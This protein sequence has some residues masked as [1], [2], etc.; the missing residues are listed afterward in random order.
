[1][2][3]ELFSPVERLLNSL[4]QKCVH[5]LLFLN[6][7]VVTRLMLIFHTSYECMMVSWQ[8]VCM[9]LMMDLGP[10]GIWSKASVNVF[11]HYLNVPTCQNVWKYLYMH[12]LHHPDPTLCSEKQEKSEFFLTLPQCSMYCVWIVNCNHLLILISFT[13]LHGYSALIRMN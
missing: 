12:V 10:K 7:C 6:E 4:M 8:H 2:D 3:G 1:M 13:F 5:F 11:K 9:S